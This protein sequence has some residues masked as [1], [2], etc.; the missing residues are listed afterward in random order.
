MGNDIIIGGG[1]V[2]STISELFKIENVIDIKNPE[3]LKKKFDDVIFMH[4]CITYTENF[5][6]DVVRYYIKY[7]PLMV[8]I[9]STISP[10]TTDI[11]SEY[12]ENTVIYSPVRGVHSRFI[13]D[14]KRYTKFYAVSGIINHDELVKKF[15]D[16]CVDSGLKIQSWK[17]AKDLEF[18]KIMT[19]TT[20]YGWIIVYRY[21]TDI[22][23]KEQ[24]VDPEKIWEFAKEIHENLGNRPIMKTDPNGIGGHCVLPN[25]DLMHGETFNALRDVILRINELRKGEKE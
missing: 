16:E 24:G 25:L 22:I 3:T 9:H 2:G 12:I 11:I 6:S 15:E 7:R 14:M 8:V 19:D 4:V 21:V 10:G 23:A 1:Q 13:E 5:I 17:N 18:A 20:Y